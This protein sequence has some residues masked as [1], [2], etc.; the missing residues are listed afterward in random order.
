M[1]K[2]LFT[3]TCLCLTIVAVSHADN[4][5]VIYRDG[6][7]QSIPLAQPSQNIRALELGEGGSSAS[8]P[9]A[10]WLAS[11][12]SRHVTAAGAWMWLA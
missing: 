5:T 4:L 7:R 2:L 11:T 1:K 9:E 6:P 10:P 3:L 8:L 12:P